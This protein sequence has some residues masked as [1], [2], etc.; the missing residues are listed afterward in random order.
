LTRVRQVSFWWFLFSIIS[1]IFGIVLI[2][3]G[4]CFWLIASGFILGQDNQTLV[5][6]SKDQNPGVGQEKTK[7]GKPP[8][9]SQKKNL[10]S[11][12]QT[13]N[14]SIILGLIIQAVPILAFKQAT[15]ANKRLENYHQERINIGIL[16][17]LL[18]ATRQL[19]FDYPEQKSDAHEGAK[20]IIELAANNWLQAV[21]S[22][23]DKDTDAEKTNVL[24]SV[25]KNL[26][27][28]TKETKDSS[29]NN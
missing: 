2:G 13:A 5:Q 4:V 22:D 29:E 6:S 25:V 16:S 28:L 27:S 8:P 1:S 19:S 12:E 26:P 7:A 9:E 20:K 18:A 11:S 23:K 15:E 3:Y 17:L 21:N 10:I 24:E 14:L